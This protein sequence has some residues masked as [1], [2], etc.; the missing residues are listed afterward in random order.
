[1]GYRFGLEQQQWAYGNEGHWPGY[2]Y[3]QEQDQE[4]WYGPGHGQSGSWSEVD[5]E[6][7]NDSG[8][9][10][11]GDDSAH[12]DSPEDNSAF[13]SS[14]ACECECGTTVDGEATLDSASEPASPFPDSS[15]HTQ[16]VVNTN[17]TGTGSRSRTLSLPLDTTEKPSEQVQGIEAHEQ[18]PNNTNEY[19]QDEDAEKNNNN[20]ERAGSW[21]GA[22]AVISEELRGI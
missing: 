2:A 6:V 14:M 22:E 15:K 19:K 5:L 11:C 21:S 12:T 4:Q 13:E 8:C 1:M 18:Q 7:G 10:G 3:G 17:G 9:C 20:R 16:D